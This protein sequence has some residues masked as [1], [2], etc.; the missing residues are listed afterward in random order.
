MIRDLS[1]KSVLIT[2]GTRGIGLAAGLAFAARGARCILT[3]RWGSADEGDV[4]SRF[5]AAGGPA[6][7]LVQSDAS[8][9]EDREALIFS[10]RSETGSIDTLI[11]GVAGATLVTGMDDLNE[12]ALTKTMQYTVWP[13]IGYVRSIGKAFAHYPR[14]I[15]A[16]SSPGPD[17]FY[18]NYDFAAASKASLEALC[19]YLGHRLRREGVRVNVVRTTGI[20]TASFNDVFGEEFG[21]FMTRFVPERFLVHENEVAGV[22]LALCSGLLDGISGQVITVDKGFVFADNIMRLYGEREALGL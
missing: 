22:I 20:R 12:R 16:L 19:R 2:G 14:Y 13:T 7:L 21:G 15:V 6:P 18:M 10:L 4:K 3:Y 1:G 17:H 11:S 5:A 9:E 8:S